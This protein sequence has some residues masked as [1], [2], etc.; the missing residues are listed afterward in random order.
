MPGRVLLL[1]TNRCVTPDPVFPLGLAHLNAALRRAGHET[2]W[3]DGQTNGQSLE[4]ALRGFQPDFVGISLRNIDD[5]LIRKRE[6]YFN[7]LAALCQAVRRM[8]PCPVILGGSG[9]SIF[10]EQL[11]KLSGADFGV[12]GEG[13]SSLAAL[14]AALEQGADYTS[15]PGLVWRR[16]AEV[17]ANPSR[18]AAPTDPL[19]AADLPAELARHYL[20]ASGM[21]NVQTQRGCAHTCCYCTYPIIEGRAPRRR[22]PAVVVEELARLEARGARYVF[23][24]D[25]IF[26]SSARHVVETCE[27]IR[28]RRLQVRWGCFLRPEGLTPELMSVMARAGLAH[29]EFGSDSLCDAVLAEYGKQFSFEDVCRSN[30]L[31]RQ[32]GIDCCHF[33]IC[34][35]PGETLDTLETSFRNA[36]RLA[37]AIILA[38]VGMRV[39]PGTRLHARAVREGSL[40]AD[41]D[42]LTPHYYLAPGLEA[43]QV[44]SKLE[45][46]ARRAPNWIVGDP[47]PG[48]AQLVARL[49]QRGVLGPLWS[50][51]ALLQRITPRPAAPVTP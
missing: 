11:L 24:V 30:E 3:L 26:N 15:I 1:S 13:E 33:L 5:V 25:S 16:G 8:R 23:V 6:T 45:G 31:A 9:F 36:G 14:L 37:G 42:L 48:Y 49:R 44:F 4:E 32:E 20:A 51:L 2:R 10:P 29:V 43:A 22:P 38:V 28:R 7:D 27:A 12:Q 39:Y 40:A 50:Y 46:F 19:E 18:A 47:A 17:V 34:G 41:A 35:G 21:L